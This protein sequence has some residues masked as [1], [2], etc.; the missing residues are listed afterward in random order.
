MQLDIHLFLASHAPWSNLTSLFC[1]LLTP[2]PPSMEG[3]YVFHGH[4]LPSQEFSAGARGQRRRRPWM[5]P[6]RHQLQPH[7][8]SSSP[9]SHRPTTSP[10]LPGWHR[11]RP[12]SR[13]WGIPPANTHTP[14]KISCRRVASRKI[15]LLTG[16]NS[17][18]CN[19]FGSWLMYL[20][21]PQKNPSFRYAL[22]KSSRKK[23]SSVYL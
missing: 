22:H 21:L 20:T 17:E 6:A 8:A 3:I 9:S 2:L 4:C 23:E 12:A 1:R 11:R 13:C 14:F 10:L 7:P 18:Y 16:R 15:P 5:P 19:W